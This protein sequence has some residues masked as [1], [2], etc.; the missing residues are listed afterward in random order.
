MGG[1]LGRMNQVNLSL[2][3]GFLINIF[4]MGNKDSV[5]NQKYQGGSGDVYRYDRPK[6]TTCGAQHLSMCI[7]CTD[8]SF[9]CC[10]RVHKIKD[11]PIIKE[12]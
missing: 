5:S 10:N 9:R 6:C 7:A 8:C 12:K 1:G 11:C 4:S 3:R 2:R